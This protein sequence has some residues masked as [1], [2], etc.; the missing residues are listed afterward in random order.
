MRSGHRAFERASRD[1]ER[2]SL[3]TWTVDARAA[4]TPVRPM[5]PEFLGTCSSPATVTVAGLESDGR[6]PGAHAAG[7]TSPVMSTLPVRSFHVNVAVALPVG[8]AFASP[9]SA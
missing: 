4:S 9:G 6:V 5:G 2:F 7:G 8:F 1:Y 3:H